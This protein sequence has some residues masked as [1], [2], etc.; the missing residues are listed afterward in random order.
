MIFPWQGELA[1]IG[2]ASLRVTALFAV[3]PFFGHAVVPPRVRMAMA[4]PIAVVIAPHASMQ[5]IPTEGGA[6]AIAGAVIGE[7]LVGVTLGFAVRL[8]FVGLDVLGEVAS[9]QGGLGAAQVLNPASGIS[10]AALGSVFGILGLATWL[11]IGG[12]HDLLRA[13][14][15]S[16]E[17]LPA[18]GG[19]PSPDSLIAVV[20]L[21]APVFSLGL[22][23]AAPVTVAMIVSNTA[24]GILGRVIPQLNLITLQLPAHV[25]MTLLIL[26]LGAHGM[27]DV[28]DSEMAGWTDRSLAALVGDD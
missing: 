27:I 9:I 8:V 10:S 23:L 19:G 17:L 20:G 24:V 21:A 15:S 1:S 6:F 18:G 25:A 4:L 7:V 26:S 12:H 13:L 14:V 11:A 22:Q 28:I 16:Y 5:G 3:A 2:A